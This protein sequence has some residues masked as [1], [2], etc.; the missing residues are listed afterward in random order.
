MLAFSFSA[1]VFSHS[2]DK[3]KAWLKA[4]SIEE[5]M[6]WRILGGN[7]KKTIAAI[8]KRTIAARRKIAKNPRLELNIF[9]S[10]EGMA[11]AR[12]WSRRDTRTGS[13]A[14]AQRDGAAYLRSPRAPGR[15]GSPMRYEQPVFVPQSRHV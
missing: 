4:D 6:P 1:A 2:P 3:A 13:Q 12:P 15:N 11:T 14:P 7:W 10:S 8:A 5:E 9:G